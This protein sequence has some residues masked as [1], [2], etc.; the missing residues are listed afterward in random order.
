MQFAVKSF[1]GPT[2][3]FKYPKLI[4][5]KVLSCEDLLEDKRLKFTFLTELIFSDFG[6]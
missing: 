2:I 6:A 4:G 1:K 5:Q 3:I